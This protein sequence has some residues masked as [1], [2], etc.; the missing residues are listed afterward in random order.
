MHH[1]CLST[2]PL[3]MILIKKPQKCKLLFSD[4]DECS[5]GT[6]NCHEDAD[7]MNIKGSFRCRCKTGY[8]GSGVNCT[9]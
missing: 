9:G 5:Q 7:C 2:Q 3:L 8:A 4:I 6:D 1:F